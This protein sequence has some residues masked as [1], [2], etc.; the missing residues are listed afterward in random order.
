MAE[1][2][3]IPNVKGHEFRKV[4]LPPET[5]R[6]GVITHASILTI[7]SYATR[8]SPVIRGKWILE[9]LINAPPPAPPNDIPS[10]DD[11]KIGTD[12]SM[13][14]QLAKHRENP[15]CASCHVRMDPL[16]FGLE[17][18]DAIGA[19][20]TRDGNLEIDSSGELP[21]GRTFKGPDEL[22]NILAAEKD[23]FA[24]CISD[25]MLT[26]ALGRG[27]NRADRITVKSIAGQLARD[28]YRFSSLVLGIVNSPQFSMRGAAQETP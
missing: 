21:D 17:N 27:L 25:K 19:W 20:R 23:A 28:D 26:Y 22:K 11:A 9:N 12:I 13:R 2:Y 15:T 6:G 4:E 24:E 5:H 16:G 8:T 3:G 10:L 14:E 7:S 1:F 18:F